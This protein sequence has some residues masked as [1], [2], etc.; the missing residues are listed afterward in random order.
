MQYIEEKVESKSADYARALKSLQEELEAVNYYQ[1]RFVT[2]TDSELKEIVGH[3]R[4]EEIEHA[5]MLV[6]WLR[7][8]MAGWDERLRT[9]LF[10]SAPLTEVESSGDGHGGQG[11]QEGAGDLVIRALR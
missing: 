7:R 10:T 11:K 3:N 9:Y 4:D 2:A 6:E 8:N 5:C 1:Q